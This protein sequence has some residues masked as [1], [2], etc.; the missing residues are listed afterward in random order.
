MCMIGKIIKKGIPTYK[1][2]PGEYRLTIV[3]AYV[4]MVCDQGTAVIPLGMG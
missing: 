1:G 2:S 4:W 3:L